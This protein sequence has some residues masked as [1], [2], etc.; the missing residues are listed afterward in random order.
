MVEISHLVLLII[1]NTIVFFNVIKKYGARQEIIVQYILIV[2]TYCIAYAF[3]KKTKKSDKNKQKYMIEIN[4]SR[5]NA[6][7][8][9]LTAGTFIFVLRT[10][11]GT[12]ESYIRV[13]GSQFF[14]VLNVNSIFYIYYI[15]GRRKKSRIYWINIILY[16][17]MRLFQG[18]TGVIF[19][20]FLYELYFRCRNYKWYNQAITVKKFFYII[21]INIFIIFAG[22]AMYSILQPLKYTIRYGEKYNSIGISEGIERLVSR[23]SVLQSSVYALIYRNDILSLYNSQGRF[24]ECFSFIRPLLPTFIMSNKNFYSLGNS[25]AAGISGI[26]NINISDSVGIIYFADLLFESN[27]IM[28]IIWLC[29]YILIFIF[30]RKVIK[31]IEI[32][33]NEFDIFYYLFIYACITSGN[34]ETSFSQTYFKLLFFFPVLYVLGIISFKKIKCRETYAP[35]EQLK[36]NNTNFNKLNTKNVTIKLQEDIQ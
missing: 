16:V 2:L 30:I 11:I 19:D 28:G 17:A 10:R 18:W 3:Y 14:S 31:L 1:S 23:F 27:Y 4:I 21:M 13:F 26:Y 22:G 33:N 36:R 5:L 34:I 32:Q 20:V 9:F 25:I 12:A 15:L 6:F 7:M 35:N 29:V 24:T 8:F